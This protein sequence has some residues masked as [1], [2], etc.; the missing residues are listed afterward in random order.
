MYRIKVRAWEGY[1]RWWT[2]CIR[3][4]MCVCMRAHTTK[5]GIH[6]VC[7][8]ITH[9]HAR[10]QIPGPAMCST[11]SDYKAT[12]TLHAQKHTH[13]CVLIY[14][15]IGGYIYIYI[16]HIYIYMCVWWFSE[17]Y[18]CMFFSLCV[19]ACVGMDMITSLLET[20]LARERAFQPV[21]VL[22]YVCVCFCVHFAFTCACG[23]C[24][25]VCLHGLC[26]SFDF[27]NLMDALVWSTSSHL[28]SC[29][30]FTI[31]ST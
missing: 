21:H 2:W 25:N 19:C 12:L 31:K 27:L 10:R 15:N 24:V 13:T 16:Y 28:G 20:H 3:V 4:Y 30:C 8:Y 17:S 9:T 22:M 29:F 1:T 11:F 5:L 26:F 14:Y 23:S 18:M 7:V 6:S